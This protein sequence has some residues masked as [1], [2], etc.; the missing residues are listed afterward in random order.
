MLPTTVEAHYESEYEHMDFLWADNAPKKVF[1]KII[2]FLSKH[3][4]SSPAGISREF[5]SPNPVPRRRLPAGGAGTL[6]RT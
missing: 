3:A 2:D 4:V 5:P 6:A 1:P